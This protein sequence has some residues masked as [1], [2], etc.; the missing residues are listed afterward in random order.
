M[1]KPKPNPNCAGDMVLYIADCLSYTDLDFNN[2][3]YPGIL[4]SQWIKLQVS[5]N[6]HRIIANIYMPNSHPTTKK[7]QFFLKCT[8]YLMVDFNIDLLRYE[9]QH[10]TN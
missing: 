7:W 2:S 1:H 8:I 3:F 9:Q 4:E 10:G 5:K 6:E